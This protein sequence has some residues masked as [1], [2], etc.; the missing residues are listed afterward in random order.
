MPLAHLV[1]ISI[2]K[3]GAT[4]SARGEAAQVFATRNETTC[5]SR[6]KG[7][8]SQFGTAW[9]KG[10]K[11]QRPN[12]S[13]V[14]CCC[15]HVGRGARTWDGPNTA[16]NPRTLSEVKVLSKNFPVETCVL[17]VSDFRHSRSGNCALGV[18]TIQ[19]ILCD[20]NDQYLVILHSA[21]CSFNISTE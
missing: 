15:C 4:S 11:E 16:A 21:V 17:T 5:R 2:V 12:F 1:V 8:S 10:W 7:R 13:I 19:V 14:G 20:E 3:D 9:L 6:S 18:I